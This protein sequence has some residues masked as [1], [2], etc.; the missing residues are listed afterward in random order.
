M[1]ANPGH[2]RVILF[3][4]S[5]S[6][7]GEVSAERVARRSESLSLLPAA[8]ELFGVAVYAIGEY[9][10]A[11]VPARLQEITSVLDVDGLSLWN[12]QGFAS[13]LAV[14][15]VEVI[16]LG[17][18]W[19]EEEV[20]IAALEGAKLGYDMRIIADL[21]IARREGDRSLVF[22]RLALHGVL[23]TT[24]RQALLEWAVCLDDPVVKQS[25]QHLLS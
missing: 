21:S 4:P 25:V 17:G 19:L 5:R 15:N 13:S 11:P 20:F 6:E 24:V 22:H 23:T 9:R 14:S 8:Q 3:N 7:L 10:S 18:A 12:D 16:F 1:L 2:S